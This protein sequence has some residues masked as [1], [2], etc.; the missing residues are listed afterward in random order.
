MALDVQTSLE[1]HRDELMK[2]PHVLNVRMGKKIVDGK[3]TDEDAVIVY[4]TEKLPL[5]KLKVADR[6]PKCLDGAIETDVVELKSPDF[7]I[8]RTSMDKI[9]PEEWGKKV[10]GLRR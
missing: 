3:P 4:V 6:V 1:K 9:S 2:L 7:K 8:G 10:H 5:K